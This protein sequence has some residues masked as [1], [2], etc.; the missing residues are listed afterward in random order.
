LTQFAIAFSALIH[1]VDHPGVS[2]AQLVKK[3]ADVAIYYQDR[4][5]RSGT[6]LGYSCL[7]T[8][9]EI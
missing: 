6:E 7:G 5:E 2:N 1:A 4:S 3:K 9:D 8:F